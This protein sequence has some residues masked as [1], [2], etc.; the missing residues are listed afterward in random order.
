MILI[1]E[2]SIDYL[3]SEM[4]TKKNYVVSAI[5]IKKAKKAL[6]M[7]IRFVYIQP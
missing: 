3:A 5:F 7:D 6:D 1:A 4:E 2:E